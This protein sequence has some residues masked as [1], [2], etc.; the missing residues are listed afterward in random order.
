MKLTQVAKK[1]HDTCYEGLEP[2][3]V[4][5]FDRTTTFWN[6]KKIDFYKPT[7]YVAMNPF[8]PELHARVGLSL[9]LHGLCCF[10]N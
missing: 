8:R 2:P 3:G 9:S 10:G 5:W 7:F 1:W 4:C 6:G